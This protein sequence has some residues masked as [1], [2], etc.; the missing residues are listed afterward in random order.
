MKNSDDF[1]TPIQD[2]DEVLCFHGGCPC[3]SVVFLS[4]QISFRCNNFCFLISIDI[5]CVH[6]YWQGSHMRL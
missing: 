6:W 2:N 3:L 4:I 1:Y 5:L